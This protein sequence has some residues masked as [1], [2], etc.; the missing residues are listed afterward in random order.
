GVL[1]TRG[2]Q[3]LFCT[4]G[5]AVLASADGELTL[6]KGRAAFIPARAPV[7]AHGPAVLYRA[8]T[9]LA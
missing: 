1:T 2:P 5:A 7:S 9:N 8:T 6:A 3:L 4:E